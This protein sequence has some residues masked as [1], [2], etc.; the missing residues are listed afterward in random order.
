MGAWRSVQENFQAVIEGSKKVLRYV[1]RPEAASPA[2][3]SLKRHQ[4]EQTDLVENAFA[5]EIKKPVTRRK[6]AV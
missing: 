5:Q 6:K 2:A 1:G 4:Q 3:G